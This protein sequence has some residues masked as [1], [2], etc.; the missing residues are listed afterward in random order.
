M[1]KIILILLISLVMINFVNASHTE[2]Y[3]QSLSE[4]IYSDCM[5]KDLTIKSGVVFS[6][7]QE[8]TQIK[9]SEMNLALV[10]KLIQVIDTIP[11][12]NVY[13][14]SP[15]GYGDPLECGIIKCGEHQMDINR[16]DF[17]WDKI[18][19]MEVKEEY[20]YAT[21]QGDN[22]PVTTG[23]DSPINQTNTWI[24]LFWS[25]GTLGGIIISGIVWLITRVT[26][27]KLNKRKRKGEKK[28]DK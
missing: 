21:T 15:C 13:A 2:E 24:Q 14:G 16:D 17:Y 3:I 27:A 20:I 1:K 10:L 9:S 23:D 12:G 5:G 28:N 7:S 25:K 6:G 8:I 19:F 26:F 4:K 18:K 22:S 11:W